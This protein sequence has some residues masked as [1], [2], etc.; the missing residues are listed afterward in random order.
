MSDLQERFKNDNVAVLYIFCDYKDRANQTDYNLLANL[1]K[2]SILQQQNI[3]SEARDLHS[4]CK[5]GQTPVSL[6]ECLNLLASSIKSF[7]KVFL[8]VDALDEHLIRNEGEYGLP[9]NTKLL[10][11]L[12]DIQRRD[13]VRLN[14]FVTSREGPGP[15]QLRRL[16]QL[17][18]RAKNEDVQSFVQS[19][20]SEDAN[21]RLARLVKRRPGLADEVTKALVDK[22]CGM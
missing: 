20:L 13:A 4:K 12:Q 14:L 22:A 18:I 21:S 5:N 15:N 7:D 17:E 3:P 10:S 1:T 16:N 6:K 9:K 11:A 8:V 2:Q 19:Q